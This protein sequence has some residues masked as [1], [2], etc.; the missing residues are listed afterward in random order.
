MKT[1][2]KKTLFIFLLGFVASTQFLQF[3][4][5]KTE[6]NSNI[7]DITNKLSFED[8]VTLSKSE[9]YYGNLRSRLNY[10]L[11]NPIIDNSGKNNILINN[12]KQI[13]DF[14]R[15]AEWNIGRGLHIDYIKLLFT[16]PDEIMKKI[17]DQKVDK[18][19]VKQQIEILKKANIIV[20]NEVDIGMPRTGYKNIAGELAKTLGYNYAF[21]VE[22]VEVDHA[23]LGLEDNEYSEE[24]ILFPN[25]KYVVDKK[26]YKGL[27]GNAILSQFPLKNVRIRRLP[28]YYDWFGS[29]KMKVT[30]IE[31]IRREAAEKIF[32]E[33]VIREIRQGSRIALLADVEIPGLKQPVTIIA[34]HLE[35]RV[36]P[37]YR[38]EQ[39]KIL[40]DE[41]KNIDNPVIMAGDFNTTSS[42]GSPTSIKRELHKRLEDPQFI[43]KQILYYAVP[44][45]FAVSTAD[46]VSTALRVYKNPAVA[47][48]PVISPNKERKLFLALQNFKFTDGGKFD[49]SGNKYKSSNGRNHLLANSNQRDLRGFTPTFIFQRPFFIGKYKLDWIFVK[50]SVKDSKSDK[51][52][53]LE[54]FY[55]R[56]LLEMN[57]AFDK[58]LS[59]HSPITVDLPLNPPSATELKAKK[60]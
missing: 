40:L 57:Y 1:G 48:I 32:K 55:G 60:L 34:A 29:E 30:E 54:P 37:K 4:Q 11:Y 28:N 5:A 6:T 42:D 19:K 59:D 41:I 15:V 45:S 31:Y 49:F 33:D 52:V 13:G 16:S 3:S 17:S 58:P 26:K 7:S 39:I 35:N 12:E 25:K 22:F 50:P 20:L 38:Y 43:A 23:H 9:V 21:G 53:E 36:I 24:R 44:Y 47:N 27:H 10:V 51:I 18:K 8:L 14:I 56:T 46:A 2:F